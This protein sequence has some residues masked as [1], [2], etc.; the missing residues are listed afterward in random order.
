MK[1][2]SEPAG[3][4]GAVRRVGLASAAGGRSL[5]VPKNVVTALTCF[6]ARSHEPAPDCRDDCVFEAGA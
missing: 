5:G 6:F 1:V 2:E 3:G 4:G